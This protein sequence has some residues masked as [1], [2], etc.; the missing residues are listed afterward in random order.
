MITHFHFT[1]YHCFTVTSIFCACVIFFSF[2]MSA[3][4]AP[5][6][7]A[8]IKNLLHFFDLSLENTG[9]NVNLRIVYIRITLITYIFRRENMIDYDTLFIETL[10]R[11]HRCLLHS[12]HTSRAM[13]LPGRTRQSSPVH[14][15]SLPVS[16]PFSKV[17]RIRRNRVL[18]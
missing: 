14:R 4:N 11:K 6:F 16:V 5:N 7:F 17:S 10:L 18:R 12:D 13:P 2:R 15:W 1:F 8:S 9:G 3:R